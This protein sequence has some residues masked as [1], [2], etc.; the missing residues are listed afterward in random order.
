MGVLNIYDIMFS[1]HVPAYTVSQKLHV[2]KATP[3]VACTGGGVC[4]LRLPSFCALQ[5][6][7]YVLQNVVRKLNKEDAVDHCKWRK[8]I[9]EVR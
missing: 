1:P 6:I 9:K 8:V 3:E 2:L 7:Y 5:L 4:S